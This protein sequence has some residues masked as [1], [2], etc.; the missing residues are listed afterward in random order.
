[1]LLTCAIA[2]LCMII[3]QAQ[4]SNDEAFKHF[5][6]LN[7]IHH[8]IVNSSLEYVQL[9]VHS[10]DQAAIDK[11]RLDHI[12]LIVKSKTEVEK[13]TGYKGQSNL[14]DEMLSVLDNY[15]ES[16][17]V[18]FKALIALK[19]SSESS[20]EAMQKYMD[21]QT[22][23][24]KKL[25]AAADRFLVAQR[26]FA[27]KNDI[28]LVES[29]RNSEIEQI[30]RLSHY[31]RA[32][33]LR[34]FKVYKHNDAFMDALSKKDAKLMEKVRLTLIQEATEEIK[35]LQQ[36]PDFNGDKAYKES[37]I[38]L[39]SFLKSMA[40]D[41]YAKLVAVLRKK[42]MTQEDVDVY[43]GVIN[44]Y[45][46]EYNKLIDAYSEAGNRLLKN[47]VPKPAVQTKQI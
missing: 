32:I 24:E 47:N 30:N 28:L 3:A 39:V 33:F 20:Y 21:A 8:N 7:N 23:A 40:E 29:E 10:N 25:G 41:G 17:E 27:K 26:E 19:L 5:E 18:E 14:R 38:Q 34:Y 15:R 16:F 46:E 6:F 37:T 2:A 13:S 11:K 44:T 4:N 9:S 36:M 42:E 45:N 43:N 31:H 35:K 22:A 12:L 1:M